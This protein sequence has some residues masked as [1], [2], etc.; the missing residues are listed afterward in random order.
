MKHSSR[1]KLSF[2][3]F[4]NTCKLIFERHTGINYKWFRV[5]CVSGWKK[6]KQKTV[7]LALYTLR[8]KYQTVLNNIF[9]YIICQLFFFLLHDAA[10]GK[11]SSQTRDWTQ[12]PRQW[13]C[14][15]LTTGLP[16]N[17]QYAH[18]LMRYFSR[19]VEKAICMMFE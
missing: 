4:W 5:C 2:F 6:Q 1:T 3:T 10:C 17:S 15:V 16:G 8:K 11:L 9:V 19:L 14:R 18:I 13:T 7:T 12:D